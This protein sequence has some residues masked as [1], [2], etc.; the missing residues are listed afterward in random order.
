LLL[1]PWRPLVAHEHAGR[2]VRESRIKPTFV[3]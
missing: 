1:R 2:S 3:R